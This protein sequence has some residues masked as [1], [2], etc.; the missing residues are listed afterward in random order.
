MQL[1]VEHKN[2]ENCKYSLKID[3]PYSE[4]KSEYSNVKNEISK[5]LAIPGFR[6]GKV[7]DAIVESRFKKA[8][9][10]KVV[11]NLFPKAYE[12]AIQ[13]NS[14]KPFGQPVA[15]DIGEYEKD[16]PL[17]LNLT[18]DRMP[19]C[20]LKIKKTP[21]ITE[22]IYA[23][24]DN[25][26]QNEINR[27]LRSRAELKDSDAEKPSHGNYVKFNAVFSDEEFASLSLRDYPLELKSE[28]T[29]PLDLYNELLSCSKGKSKIIKKAFQKDFHNDKL[30][31]KTVEI[32]ITINELKT[33][34]YPELTDELAKELKYNSS[35]DMK[36]K[37]KKSLEDYAVSYNNNKARTEILKQIR[38]QSNFEVPESMIQYTTNQYLQQ[39]T[40]QFSNNQTILDS[41]LASRKQ[42]MDDLRKEYTTVAEENI[43][44]ELIMEEVIK[45]NKLDI[46]E[47]ELNNEIDKYAKQAGQPVET[48]K[49]QLAASGQQNQIRQQLLQTKAIATLKDKSKVKKG[50]AK[51]ISE[52]LQ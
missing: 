51:Q 9:E 16:K 2:I 6:K 49:Q 48:Y 12:Q 23:I 50:K 41:Y 4:L 19:S 36:E 32:E 18:V 20:A 17:T 34:N 42:T 30:A 47:E 35:S 11:Q 14:L 21:E 29:A 44:N 39:L 13:E 43:K 28:G 24:N 31:G 46:N 26:I 45:E 8:I 25:D 22:D 15:E 52:I 37:T 40:G 10:A 7:P 5:D 1:T 33:L 38:E 27:Q 3:I